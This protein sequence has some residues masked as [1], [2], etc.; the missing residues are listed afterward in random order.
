MK[1]EELFKQ[2]EEIYHR[3]EKWNEKYGEKTGKHIIPALEAEEKLFDA[4]SILEL[5]LK[6]KTSSNERIGL[7]VSRKEL[8]E[9]LK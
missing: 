8:E 9:L 2:L 3:L 4:L 6:E 7:I 1:N 5:E